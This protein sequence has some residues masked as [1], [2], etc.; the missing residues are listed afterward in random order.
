MQNEVMSAVRGAIT[1]VMAN[2][3]QGIDLP[4]LDFD[5]S[6]QAPTRPKPLPML[7][8]ELERA[9]ALPSSKPRARMAMSVVVLT[10]T[11]IGAAAA[12]GVATTAWSL[13][14]RNP[15]A[16]V[17]TVPGAEPKVLLTG[18]PATPAIAAAKAVVA[19]TLMP[20]KI[21]AT[22]SVA[23]VVVP[24]PIVASV[25]AATSAPTL[26]AQ[27]TPQLAALPAKASEPAPQRESVESLLEHGHILEARR[28]LIEEKTIER[29][30]GALTM[31]R[32]F[33]PNYLLTL[34]HADAGP[35]IA[36]ARRWYRRWYELAIKD[37]AVPESIRVDLLLQSLDRTAAQ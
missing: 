9:L 32:S 22:P 35:D 20:A 6:T 13:Y 11:A 5:F 29:S 30:G 15:A 16:Q 31:A 24:A 12:A 28:L 8:A 21:D 26:A 7:R 37:G 23:V 25:Q 14:A 4:E 36:E 10:A 33:D 3:V 27:P 1:G 2:R 34:S 19:V 17:A 18:E